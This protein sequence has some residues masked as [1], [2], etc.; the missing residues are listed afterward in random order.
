[1]VTL[2]AFR[3]VFFG[4]PAFAVPTLEALLS[5]RHHVLAVV[6]QPDRPSGRGRK[7]TDSPVKARASESRVPVLQPATL[8]GGDFASTL[9][10]LGADMGIVAAYGKIL[11]EAV[12]QAPRQGMLNVHASL[13]PK[14][15]GA[16]PVHRAVIAGERETGITIMRIV[17]ALDAG[18]MLATAVRPIDVSETSEEVERG[19][20]VI[21][22]SL[23]VWTLDRIAD[24]SVVESPQDESEAT[25]APRITKDDGWIDWSQ[26]ALAIHNLVR[27]LH[28]WP[29]ASSFLSGQRVIV[30]RTTVG[31]SPSP[32][33][34][35]TVTSVDGASFAVAAG[36]GV[37]NVLELQLEGRR[38]MSARDF[39]AGH[40]LAPGDRFSRAQ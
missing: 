18:P 26:P 25:Y 38:R 27:G 39:L 1:M 22:A 28:P 34:P 5:S 19:L 30:L 37:V 8:K 6:T 33:V 24:G 36:R 40:P 4:T 13:L 17:Q 14:Y 10:E 20:A 16:A 11:P 3:V 29:H 21:G 15:R 12:I 7:V 35:G 2:D 9:R 32:A 23:L 31:E